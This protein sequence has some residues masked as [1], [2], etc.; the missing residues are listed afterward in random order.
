M[1][2]AL[3]AASVMENYTVRSHIPAENRGELANVTNTHYCLS[4]LL[5]RNG[6]FCDPCMDF[7]SISQLI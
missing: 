3:S 7:A 2:T 4:V 1:Y 6:I 5:P